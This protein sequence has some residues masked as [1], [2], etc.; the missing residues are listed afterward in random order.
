M[1]LLQEILRMSNSRQTEGVKRLQ[2]IHSLMKPQPGFVKA[3]DDRS[4]QLAGG[5]RRLSVKHGLGDVRGRG[6]LLA[7]DLPKG[8]LACGGLGRRIRMASRAASASGSSPSTQAIN[9]SS[10]TPSMGGPPRA[11]AAPAVVRGRA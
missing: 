8:T 4:V 9:C 10:V 5:L 2:W 3:V 6:L 1:F 11:P 7:L